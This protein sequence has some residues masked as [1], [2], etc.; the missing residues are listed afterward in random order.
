[1][2]IY[3]ILRNIYTHINGHTYIFFL[4]PF[5]TVAAAQAFEFG[6]AVSNLRN[7]DSRMP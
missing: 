7:L 6:Y 1:M 5:V 2:Y 4:R 3:I